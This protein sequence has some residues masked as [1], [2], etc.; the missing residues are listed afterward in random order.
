MNKAASL[1][2]AV[3][4]LLFLSCRGQRV[5]DFEQDLNGDGLS[6][7]WIYVNSEDEYL[8]AIDTDGD[9]K[10][11]IYKTYRNGDLTKVETD[12]NSDR[13]IDLVQEYS[14][15]ILVREMHDDD[16][17]G[18]FEIIK[19]FRNG[20]LATVEHDWKDRSIARFDDYDD[21]GRLIRSEERLK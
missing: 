21:S 13:Q 1:I 3:L 5:A 11:E 7:R 9:G 15:G 8:V 20:K 6:D 14:E 19:T 18:T 16:Y 12:R 17:D 4:A 10:A 2:A